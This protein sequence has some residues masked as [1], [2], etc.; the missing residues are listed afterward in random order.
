MDVDVIGS[1]PGISTAIRERYLREIN[2]AQSRVL[3]ENA[4]FLDDSIISAMQASVRRGVRTVLILPPDKNHDV[5][6][7]RDAFAAVQNDVVRSGIELYKYRDRFV[8]SKVA[9]FD[10]RV[11]T[12]GSANLDNMALSKLAEV[13]LFVNDAGFTRV[14]ETRIFA[15]DI[16]NSDRE[17][18]K[19]LSWWQ[20]VKSGTLHFFRSFL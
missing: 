14:L 17:V 2:A 18:E 6:I 3:I 11:S 8:H 16:P 5:P 4:Y 19:K 7:V 10:G 20:K 9:A 15:A 1:L 12:V 13:N